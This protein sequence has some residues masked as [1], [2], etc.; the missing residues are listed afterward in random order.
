ML[1]QETTSCITAFFMKHPVLGDHLDDV[2]IALTGSYAVGLGA[3]GADVDA[4]VLCPPAVYE[5]LKGQM[6][7][8]EEF[9]EVVGDFTLESLGDVWSR[10]QAYQEMT[11]LFVYGNLV[12][13]MGNRDLL[14]PLVDH[15][16]AIPPAVLEQAIAQENT[17]LSQAEYAFLRSFQTEDSVARTL[18]RAGMVRSAMRLAFL[19]DGQAP[20]YDKHLFRLLPRTTC[21][22]HVAALAEQ[23]LSAS[24]LSVYA[25]VGAA[26]DWRAMSAA[27]AETPAARFCERIKA[28]W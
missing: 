9:V 17:E 2:C 15:C 20:P 16:R 21:G 18:A 26:E 5:A 1:A 22:R 11:S 14:T 13:L 24:D 28:L 4:K 12:Y 23:F 8:E 27:A 7:L 10:V 19:V 6:E 25:P 3:K